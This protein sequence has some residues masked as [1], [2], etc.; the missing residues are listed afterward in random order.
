MFSVNCVELL[1]FTLSAHL[2][3]KHPLMLFALP[4]LLDMLVLSFTVYPTVN[5]GRERETLPPGET[6]IK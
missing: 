3:L 6:K 2:Y 5:D 1:F 4:M